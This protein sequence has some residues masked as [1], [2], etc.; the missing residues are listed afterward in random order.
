LVGSLVGG[1]AAFIVVNWEYF[2]QHLLEIFQVYQGGLSWPGAMAGGLVLVILY[3]WRLGKP[4][5]ELLWVLFP[6]LTSIVGV[7]LL[8]CWLDGCAYGSLARG[9]F[10]LLTVDELDHR[11]LRI[12]TQLIG[13]LAAVLWY[14]GLDSQKERF[15]RL[16]PAGWV[17]ILGM[18]LIMFGLALLRVDPGLYAYG[19][20]LDAW[21]ALIF[22]AF[23]LVGVLGSRR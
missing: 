4:T 14:A 15:S 10:G 21:A 5:G 9:N 20:R 2:R 22:T 11:A 23:A 19:M 3:A 13:I 16:A 6:L 12:P 8:A 17:S 1:R 7:A 18:A